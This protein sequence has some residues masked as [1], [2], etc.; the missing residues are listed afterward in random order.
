MKVRTSVSRINKILVNKRFINAKGH[1]S[2]LTKACA[3]Y[4]TTRLARPYAGL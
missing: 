4:H 2:K 3:I 1:E